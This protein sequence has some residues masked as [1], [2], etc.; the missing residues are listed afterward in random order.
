[1]KRKEVLPRY[2]GGTSS[3][4]VEENDKIRLTVEGLKAATYRERVMVEETVK[5]IM[6][7]VTI[8]V[9]DAAKSAKKEDC[10]IVLKLV[11]LP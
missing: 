6:M 7:G 8:V 10:F 9:A 11:H 3:I 1:M 4:L 2:S 5:R